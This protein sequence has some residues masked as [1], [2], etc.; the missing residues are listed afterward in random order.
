VG[1]EHLR[2]TIA[3]LVEGSELIAAAVA[4]G[5]LAI[6]GANYRLLE[7]R[8]VPDLILGDIDSAG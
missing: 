6:V 5:T 2:E 3:K 7:G 4:A 8:A 1:K